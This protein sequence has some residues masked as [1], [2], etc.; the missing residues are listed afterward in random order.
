MLLSSVIL[1]AIAA[2]GGLFLATRK[3]RPLA[4]AIIHGLVA[5]A[6]LVCLIIAVVQGATGTLPVTAL[7]LL[8]IAALGGFALFAMDLR[9][10][11]L[12]KGL[13]VVHG[14]AAVVAEVLLIIAIV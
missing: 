14:L 3:E 6:G 8:V 2:L 13:V 5:A 10:K 11:T 7:I 12:S 9:S 4:V 1:F